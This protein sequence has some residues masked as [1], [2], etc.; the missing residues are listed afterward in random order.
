LLGMR[1]SWDCQGWCSLCSLVSKDKE[2]T[3]VFK[4]NWAIWWY[5]L[6]PSSYIHFHLQTALLKIRFKAETLYL[7]LSI[8]NVR[9]QD[10]IQ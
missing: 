6:L 9:A 8:T 3:T 5:L 4:S 2:S 10:I 7:Y 1:Q